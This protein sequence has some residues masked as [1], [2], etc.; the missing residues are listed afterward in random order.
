[1]RNTGCEVGRKNCNVCVV[2]CAFYM[3]DGSRVNGRSAASRAVRLVPKH[4]L[5]GASEL[6]WT[7]RTKPS[8][9][10]TVMT[11]DPRDAGRV[12]VI[13]APRSGEPDPGLR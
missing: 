13:C 4:D 8:M 9:P 7:V 3:S 2:F 5:C 10:N 1:M 11:I 6:K 12:I